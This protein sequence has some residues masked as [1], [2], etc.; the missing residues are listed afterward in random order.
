MESDQQR[1]SR[2]IALA[3]YISQRSAPEVDVAFHQLRFRQSRSRFRA[4]ALLDILH[5]ALRLFDAALLFEPPRGFGNGSPN[6]PN[7]NC[8][9]TKP[10]CNRAEDKGAHVK[11]S[12]ESAHK[13]GEPFESQE[14]FGGRR[15]YPAAVKGRSD[16]SGEKQV[17][18]FK[19]RAQGKQ[20]DQLADV[21][22]FRQPVQPG[23]YGDASAC[24]FQSRSR[25][26]AKRFSSMGAHRSSENVVPG[27]L[28]SPGRLRA[29]GP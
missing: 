11:S 7:E 1:R 18:E 6:E 8:P 17:V 16:V 4:H 28:G 15:E 5:D 10:V 21:T 22:R 23:C 9:A 13:A 20:D 2:T 25:S 12:K 27:R 26:H 29:Y 3:P 19:T 24:S 14:T